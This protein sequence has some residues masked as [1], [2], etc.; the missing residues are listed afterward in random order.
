MFC[1]LIQEEKDSAEQRAEELESQVGG[2]SMGGPVSVGGHAGA[3]GQEGMPARW[4]TFG[5]MSPPA[6]DL[7]AVP[8]PAMHP[9][10]NIT[11]Q[12]YLV[13]SKHLSFACVSLTFDQ[14]LSTWVFRKSY[15]DAII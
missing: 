6:S 11:Q 8:S 2:V 5:Q 3:G 9:R 15:S 13:V 4:H 10:S 14:H 1:R 12:K 7:P